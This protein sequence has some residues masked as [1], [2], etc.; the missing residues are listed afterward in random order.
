MGFY[1]PATIVKDAQ[2]HR[3]QFRPIDVAISG[4]DCAVE[5]EPCRGK[6]VRLVPALICSAWPPLGHIVTEVRLLSRFRKEYKEKPRLSGSA[7]KSRA[8][9]FWAGLGPV[10]PLM[11]Q[12]RMGGDLRNKLVHQRSR[13]HEA[14][15]AR[16]HQREQI[17]AGRIDKFDFTKVDHKRL[18]PVRSGPAPASFQFGNPGALEYTLELETYRSGVLVRR[19]PQHEISQSSAGR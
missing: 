13:R 7:H 9:P 3:L 6:S 4:W 12:G 11:G 15:T 10:R 5:Q 2:R 17:P 1:A 16:V 18:G 14:G 19:D 8:L